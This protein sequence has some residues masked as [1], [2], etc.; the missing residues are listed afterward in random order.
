GILDIYPISFKNPIRIEFWG[1]EIDSIREFVVSNQRSIKEYE[2]INFISKVFHS[3]N[4]ERTGDLFGYIP[5]NAII[6][7][8]EKE[9]LSTEEHEFIIPDNFTVINVNSLDNSDIK[10]NIKEQN[11]FNSSIKQFTK[12]LQEQTIKGVNIIICA[13]GKIHLARIKEL[14][15]DALIMDDDSDFASPEQTSNNILWL[16]KTISQ[17]FSVSDSNVCIYTEHQLFNRHRNVTSRS[18]ENAKFSI[19]E[20]KQLNIGDLV[21]HDDKGVGRF[22]G[23]RTVEIGGSKQDCIQL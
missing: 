4:T 1:N 7:Q 8:I 10:V 12:H 11:N 13:D 6:L 18:N 21:I 17:G 9:N 23:F 3:M 15:H 16:D 20:L 2:E 22:E 14:I 5:D 19:D